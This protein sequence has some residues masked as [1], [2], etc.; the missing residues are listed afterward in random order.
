LIDS[1]ENYVDNRKVLYISVE[2][3]P[4][5]LNKVFSEEP[6]NISSFSLHASSTFGVQMAVL[7]FTKNKKKKTISLFIHLYK[8]LEIVTLNQLYYLKST[9]PS[10]KP[11]SWETLRTKIKS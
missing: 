9:I 1:A 7:G 2:V 11:N 10:S 6:I 3:G 4:C 5:L 8:I